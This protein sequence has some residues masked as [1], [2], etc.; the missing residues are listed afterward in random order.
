MDRKP[1]LIGLLALV[2]LGFGADAAYR[3]YV[4]APFQEQAKQKEKLEKQ[5][6]DYRTQLMQT[7]LL[8]RDLPPM[9]EASLPSNPE[10]ARQQYLAWWWQTVKNHQWQNPSVDLGQP[11]PIVLDKKDKSAPMYKIGGT[12]RGIATLQQ[13]T[14]LMDAFYS[15]PLLHQIESIQMNPVAGGQALSINLSVSALSLSNATNENQL[16]ASIGE[17]ILVDQSASPGT[18]AALLKGDA[19]LPTE[20]STQASD[21]A[22][23]ATAEATELTS[24]P[25][26]SAP[27]PVESETSLATLNEVGPPAI[28]AG[29]NP[30]AE[31]ISSETTVAPSTTASAN[32]ETATTTV[33]QPATVPAGAEPVPSVQPEQPWQSIVKRNFFQAGGGMQI[34]SQVSLSAITQ[35]V[36]GTQQVWFRV[37][38]PRRTEIVNRGESFRQGVLAARVLETATDHAILQIEGSRVRVKI[39]QPLA[40]GT[41]VN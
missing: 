33:A 34:A 19:E 15:T 5:R 10:T 39:G 26:E 14:D 21:T 3:S 9:Q 41:V 18:V 1:L 31:K 8:V 36:D 38:S 40:N 37:N 27:Q 12:I 25:V 22:V 28:P 16:P 4:E 7:K 6:K 11:S 35:D 29:T 23:P 32:S 30:G 20:D 17:S 24:L 13:A 2:G